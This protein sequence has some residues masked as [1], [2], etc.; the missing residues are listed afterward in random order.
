MPINDHTFDN[1]K[2]NQIWFSSPLKFNDPYDFFVPYDSTFTDEGFRQKVPLQSGYTYEQYEQML[3]FYKQNPKEFKIWSEEGIRRFVSKVRIACFCEEKSEI[4]M[5]S[6]Y[7]DFHRGICLKFD[8]S[9]DNNF[10]HEENWTYHKMPIKNVNYPKNFEKIYILREDEK[11]FKKQAY[12]KYHKWAYE[13]E[14]RIIL[15]PEGL[16]NNL[17]ALPYNKECLVELNFGI[18]R[19]QENIEK[20]INTINTNNYPNVKFMQAVKCHDRYELKFEEIDV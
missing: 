19:K 16:P 11:D 2:K 15:L 10:F 1:L 3:Q 12:T 4:L 20:I 9:L 7:A 8:S 14:H 5:W 6:H 17:E 18:K 13:K